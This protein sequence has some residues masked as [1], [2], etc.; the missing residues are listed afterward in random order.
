MY[1]TKI[2]LFTLIVKI[3]TSNC[4]VDEMFTKIKIMVE[5]WRDAIREDDFEEKLDDLEN[6][7]EKESVS[8]DD[9]VSD[10]KYLIGLLRNELQHLTFT[11]ELF[12]DFN[13]Q[14]MYKL[15]K[16]VV[17][18][19]KKPIENLSNQMGMI[20]SSFQKDLEFFSKNATN[21]C[22]MNRKHL[23]ELVEL[24][25]LVHAA[26]EIFGTDFKKAFEHLLN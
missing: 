5:K 6:K 23:N 9:K 26:I 10:L 8:D 19:I 20:Y 21:L 16:E 17:D 25:K 22:P 14:D 1:F 4:D 13:F 7:Y 12:D 3:T 18:D 2:F 24:L 11:S 15:Q